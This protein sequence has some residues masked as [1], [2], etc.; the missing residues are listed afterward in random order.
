MENWM[1]EPL[2]YLLAAVS[3]G[4]VWLLYKSFELFAS[5]SNLQST[6]GALALLGLATIGMLFVYWSVS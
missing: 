1:L 6:S 3:A 5:G 4:Y 2:Y